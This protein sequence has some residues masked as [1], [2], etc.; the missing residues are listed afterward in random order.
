MNEI[1]YSVFE[2][3]SSLTSIQLPASVN[4]IGSFAFS[5]CSKL[6]SIKLP[7]SLNRIDGYVFEGCRSLTSIELPG[8]VNEIESGAFEDCINLKEINVDGN[9]INY[10]SKDGILYDKNQTKLICC[11]Q[12]K[13]GDIV[14]PAS[15]T[16]TGESVFS[17]CS[18]LTEIN[19]DG[20]NVKYTSKDGI[21]YDKNQT[22]LICC[23]QGKAGDIVIPASV[24]IIGRQAFIGCSKLTSIELQEGVSQIWWGAFTNCSSLSEIKLPESLTS[25]MP[26]AFSGC[27]DLTL[28][29]YK[30]SYAETYALEE[31]LTYRYIDD[32]NDCSH[33]FQTT[34]VKAT[35]KK[36]G[37]ITKTCTKCG[38]RTKEIIY[39]ATTIKLSKT[40]YT[41]NKK[42]HK[43]SVTVKDNKGKILKNKKDYTV[44]YPK[45]M[46]NVGSYTITIKLKGNY[47]GTVKKTFQIIPKGTQISKITPKKKGFALKWKKQTLQTTGYEIAYSTN[48]KFTKKTTETITIGK[49][50]AVSITVSKLKA[51]KKY[52]IKIRTYKKIKLD[53]KSKKLYSS[54]S[55][56]KTVTT[57]K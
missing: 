25:I 37:S 45:A 18:S 14:I 26:D 56:V 13:A 34:I 55:K 44:T 6:I 20:N 50:K 53:G 10:E 3:C 12:G 54:W 8:G 57:K 47:K 19:V 1:G 15:V 9:N 21:L 29:V 17:G 30:G 48:K 23:P 36:N 49:N 4:E 22:E 32:S 27:K 39:A 35:T 28:L 24:T 43:P 40:S 33:T 2:D 52:Y 42:N 5:G 38:E 31:G 11:P 46:K 16:S 51:R 7:V 41:Y